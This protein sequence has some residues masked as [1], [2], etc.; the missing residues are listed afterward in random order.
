MGSDRAAGQGAGVRE[1]VGEIVFTSPDL[2][3]LTN[4]QSRLRFSVL[5]TSD[6]DLVS[7][8][9]AG[10]AR[11]FDELVSIHQARVFALARRILGN[12]EDAADVQQETFIRAWRSLNRFRGDAGFA[13]W[14]HRITVNLCLSRRQRRETAVEDSFFADSLSHSAGPVADATLERAELA[15]ELRKVM[16]GMPAHFRVLIVLREIEGRPF[17]E[18]AQVLGCSEP[19]ARTRACRARGMLR[20]RMRP[21]LEG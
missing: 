8:A 16:A 7:R 3:S 4:R 2:A 6:R 11:A 9:Q 13:T 1:G 17:G 15:A 19:S 12:D 21:Y 5:A 10:D 14:L 20:E 18:I